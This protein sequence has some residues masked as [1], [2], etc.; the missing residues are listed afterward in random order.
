MDNLLVKVAPGCQ[1]LRLTP[2]I[3]ASVGRVTN[4]LNVRR[5]AIIQLLRAVNRFA[6][7]WQNITCALRVWTPYC[8]I[9]FRTPFHINTLIAHFRTSKD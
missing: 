5:N 3:G 9:T 6:L 8:I 7:S 4:T 2:F 1:Q